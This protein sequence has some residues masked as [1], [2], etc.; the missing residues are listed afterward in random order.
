MVCAGVREESKVGEGGVVAVAP[1]GLASGELEGGGD[2]LG[3]AG[4]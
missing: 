1:D 4:E 3:G 2:G